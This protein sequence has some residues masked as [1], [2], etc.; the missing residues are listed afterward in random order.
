MMTAGEW[1]R[2]AK[3]SET[4]FAQAAFRAQ[5][6]KL[7]RIDIEQQE[8]AA[9]RLIAALP[10]PWHPEMEKRMGEELA[11][12]EAKFAGEKFN[13]KQTA[14]ESNTLMLGGPSPRLRAMRSLADDIEAGTWA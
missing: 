8:V 11:R 13:A 14:K 4:S 3:M 10:R 1:K 6:A 12:R 7:A 9:Q 2:V 5:V